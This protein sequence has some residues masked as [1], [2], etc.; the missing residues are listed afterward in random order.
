MVKLRNN[1]SLGRLFEGQAV[2]VIDIGSNSVRL[3]VYEALNRAPTPLFNEKVLCGLGRDVSTKGKLNIESLDRALAALKRYK[4]LCDVMKVSRI[5]AIATAA[6]RDASN[7]AEFIKAASK[8][9]GQDV[10]ILSGGEEA[11]YAALGVKSGIYKSEGLVGDMGG[12]SLEL[13]ALTQKNIGEGITMPLGGLALQDKAEKSLEKAQKIVKDHFKKQKLL[14]ENKATT[15]YAVGGTFRSLA[16]LHMAETKYPLHVIQN[17]QID[18]KTAIEFCKMVLK[19]PLSQFK[20]IEDVSNQRQDLLAFGALVLLE[21]LQAGKFETLIVSALGVREGV[22][23]EALPP[24]EQKLDPLIEASYEFCVLRSRS[25]PHAVELCEWSDKAFTTLKIEESEDEK[26]LRH[27][28]CLLADIGWRAHPDY[29]GNQ[30][31]SLIS[32]AAFVGVTHVE[33]AYLALS[34]YFRHNGM[35]QESLSHEL[36][37]LATPRLL[38][39]AKITGAMMRV[40]YLISASMPHNLPLTSFEKR[41]NKIALNLPQ[42][43]QMLDG[44]R[45]QGRVKALGKLL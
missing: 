7:G 14:I 11:Y 41:D 34:I 42:S 33:R 30:S 1:V 31:L 9:I 21:I 25:T 8:I 10:R 43:L 2:A 3:V 37:N 27:A 12:G 24:D 26:R 22:L 39:L 6:S 17:Y 36:V 20:H 29:R 45:L 28:A 32:N 5:F 15:F 13:V 35:G 40:A 18:A 38:F 44:E 23:Y 19:Q 16:K 4:G